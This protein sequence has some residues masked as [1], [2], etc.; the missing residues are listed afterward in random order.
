MG[1]IME[2]QIDTREKKKEVERIEHQFDML[3][4]K[5]FRSKLYCGD[6]MNLN[7]ARLVVDRK[8]D[9]AEVCTNIC[10]QHER[11]KRELLRAK[12][13]GIF[14]IILIEHGEGIERLED[15]YF[16]INPRS[17]PSRWVMRDGHPVKV[18]ESPNAVTGPQLY[19]ALCTIQDRYDVRFEFCTKKDTG[20]KIVELLGGE[21]NA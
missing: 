2:I 12:E 8:Q 5:H 6:Y 17:L 7:N 20:A 9:L 10:Q 16:W 1:L 13:M 4:I 14:I 11:F 3:G 19:K 15:V 21:T 18:A